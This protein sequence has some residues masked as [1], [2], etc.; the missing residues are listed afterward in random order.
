MLFRS[1]VGVTGGEAGQMLTTDGTGNLIWSTPNPGTVTSIDFSGGDTGLITVGGPITSNGTITL[2]GTLNVANGGTGTTTSTGTGSVVLSDNPVL[3]S[4]NLGTP[5]FLDLSNATALNLE[6]G[7]AGVL[8][9]VNGGTGA[10]V[11]SAGYVTSDGN[12]CL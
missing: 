11:I 4:P 3:V 6:T 9:M 2:G 10:N 7:V 1:E 8:P 12:T 5:T